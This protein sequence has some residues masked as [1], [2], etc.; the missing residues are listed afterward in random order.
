[1]GP[2]SIQSLHPSKTR[3]RTRCA[4]LSNIKLDEAI[5]LTEVLPLAA[6]AR[7]R[8][9]RILVGGVIGTSLWVAPALLVAPQAQIVHI[10]T[11]NRGLIAADKL[12]SAL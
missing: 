4:A 10:S 9:F 8:D 3:W 6:E 12:T 1:V 2:V 11:L 7:R 5:G